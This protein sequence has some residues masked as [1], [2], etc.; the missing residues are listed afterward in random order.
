MNLQQEK[1]LLTFAQWTD[2]TYSVI[3]AIKT[4]SDPELS[5][6]K[7]RNRILL[8]AG[9]SVAKEIAGYFMG[10]NIAKRVKDLIIDG[11]SL[12]SSATIYGDIDVLNNLLSEDFKIILP[13][14]QIIGKQENINSY[15]EGAV[16]ITQTGPIYINSVKVLNPSNINTSVT[17]DIKAT[18]N[19]K[20]ISGKYLFRRK[21]V[22]NGD[23]YQVTES[24][25]SLIG[26]AGATPYAV[27]V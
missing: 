7:K 2:R 14:G 25:G 4:I 26:Q 6:D 27:K 8:S 12:V 22:L 16:K 17:I 1:N 24:S 10:R 3:D 5:R 19:S 18:L 13:T 21:W 11:E 9:F 23:K 15:R 20:D